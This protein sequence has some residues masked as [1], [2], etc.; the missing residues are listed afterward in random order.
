MLTFFSFHKC[1]KKKETNFKERKMALFPAKKADFGRHVES[2]R[3]QSSDLFPTI[4]HL[5][6]AH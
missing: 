4:V 1:K 6:Q 3:S 2:I 5:S